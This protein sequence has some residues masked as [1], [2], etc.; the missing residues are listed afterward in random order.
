MDA[1][2]CFAQYDKNRRERD[3]KAIVVSQPM[4]VAKTIVT[5][6]NYSNKIR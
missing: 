5:P 3:I 4:T 1:F 6:T 2:E